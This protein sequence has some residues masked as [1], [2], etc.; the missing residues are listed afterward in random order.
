[1]SEIAELLLKIGAVVFT[2]GKPIIFK[3]G[4][5]SP[6]YID[7]RCLPFWPV[8]WRSV[9][10]AFERMIDREV[11]LFDV[12]AGIAAAGIPHSAALAYTLQMPSV[13]VRKAAKDHGTRSRVEGGNVS[14][15]RVL[16]VEDLVTTGSSSLAGV[17]ALRGEG[18]LVTDCLCIVTYGFPGAKAAFDE[19]GVRLHALV[20]FRTLLYEAATLGY[21]DI[22]T[23]EVIEG[24]ARDPYN[25]LRTP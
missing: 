13:F 11:L 9:I 14:G 4:V 17:E 7:N 22:E 15:K 19:A 25:W 12:I 8:Q 16:L 2:P 20:T 3:S 24:W 10:A 6:V 21:F 23:V 5:K 18:A 1:M